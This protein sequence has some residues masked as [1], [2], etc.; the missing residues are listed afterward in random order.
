MFFLDKLYGGKTEYPADKDFIDKYLFYRRQKDDIDVDVCR[1]NMEIYRGTN[2]LIS[3]N[4]E[5][6]KQRE[7][8]RSHQKF[9]LSD[10]GQIYR[11]ET[12]VNCMQLLL[13]I[14]NYDSKE[15][16]IIAGDFEEIESGI[17][18]SSVLADHFGMWELLNKFVE[19]CGCEGNYFAIPY[20]A[21]F[22]LNRAKGR[23][24]QGG[25]GYTFVDSSD[26]Y[27][28][29]CYDY[30]VKGQKNCSITKLIDEKYM[31]WK[32]RYAGHWD[33]FI[34]DNCF[35]NFMGSDKKPIKLWNKTDQGFSTDLKNYMEKAVHV[36]S[37][38]EKRINDMVDK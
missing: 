4:A 29:V 6:I 3:R 11:G 16:V 22:S 28:R 15:E 18:K 26:T 2:P 5:I 33:V 27:F 24:R 35:Q 21:G 14:V 7:F 36:L 13:Q 32:D 31:I 10:N 30:F 17:K 19:K 25:Y 34:A 37:E 8:N 9:E 1:G 38:R 12:I 23:L 20:K